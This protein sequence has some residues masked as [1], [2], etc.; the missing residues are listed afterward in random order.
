MTRRDDIRAI[1]DHIETALFI[2]D[3]L[4]TT[5]GQLHLR[6]TLIAAMQEIHVLY[7]LAEERSDRARLQ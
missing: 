4:P 1:A 6:D 3:G 5:P 7:P 2:A